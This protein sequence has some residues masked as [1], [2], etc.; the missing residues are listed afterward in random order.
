[1]GK[2][3][4]LQV[5]YMH[6][7][8]RRDPNRSELRCRHP[9]R[10]PDRYCIEYSTCRANFRLE[11]RI[12]AQEPFSQRYEIAPVVGSLHMLFRSGSGLHPNA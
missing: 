6:V 2:L 4:S 1:M 10:N 8:L 5:G 12:Y 3:G 9:R 11:S 7:S